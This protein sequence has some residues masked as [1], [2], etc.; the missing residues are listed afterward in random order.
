LHHPPSGFGH[1]WSFKSRDRFGNLQLTFFTDGSAW[2]VDAILMMRQ[3][4]SMSFKLF[5]TP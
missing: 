3:V 4:S 2:V 5:G 1:P